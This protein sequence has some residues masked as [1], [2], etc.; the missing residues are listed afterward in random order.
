MGTT[1]GKDDLIAALR[2]RYDY[3]SAQ[4]VF[5]GALDVAGL[6]KQA[7]YNAA[8]VA[9]LQAA[10]ARVGDRLEIVEARIDEL[11]GTKAPSSPASAPVEVVE[12]PP[13]M[14]VVEKPPIVATKPPAEV[15]VPSAAVAT[16]TFSLAGIEPVEGERVL[17]CGSVLELGAW[18]DKRAVL[19]VRAGD[20]W[21]ATIAIAPGTEGEF[22]FLRRDAAG[23][24]T[25][26]SGANRDLAGGA[27]LE[28]TWRP[29]AVESD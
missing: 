12:K 26:E 5:D 13:T 16:T 22:K 20:V 18:D 7:A 1:V 14:A 9:A 24:I 4:T 8:E 3:Y 23:G 2:L 10:L 15:V 6:A 21:V 25:W 28:A 17:V 11:L 29:L 27:H 19:L